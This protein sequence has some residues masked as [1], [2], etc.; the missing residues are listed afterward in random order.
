MNSNVNILY[1]INKRFGVDEHN[2]KKILGSDVGIGISSYFIELGNLNNTNDIDYNLVMLN[3]LGENYF[4]N[5]E[6]VSFLVKRCFTSSEIDLVAVVLRI[7]VGKGAFE[8]KKLILEKS[9]AQI[10]KALIQVLKL[11]ANFFSEEKRNKIITREKIKPFTPVPIEESKCRE[12]IHK[13]Y[14]NL[15]DYQKRIKDRVIQKILF[16]KPS[17]KLLIH[18]PTGSGKTKTAMETIIDFI[19]VKLRPTDE[20]GTVVWFAHSKELCEQAYDTFKSLWLYKGDFEISTCKVFDDAD[21]VEVEKCSKEKVNV[22]FVGFQKFNSLRTRSKKTLLQNSILHF[23]KT[24]TQLVVVDEAHKSLATT[25]EEAISFTSTMPN[26]RLIGLTATPGRSN[27]ITG[28]NENDRLSGY[29]GND[30]VT[31]T[32]EKGEKVPDPLTYLQELNVLA[33]IEQEQLDFEL[34]FAH[35]GYSS[36]ELEQISESDGLGEKEIN[37]LATDPYRNMIIINKIR[38]NFN[39]G[40]SILVFAC[41]LDHCFILAGIL[42]SYSINS[43]VVTGSTGKQTRSNS[44]KAFKNGSLK[45]LINFGVLSTG[46]DAP[47]L[48]TLII[49]RPTKSIVLYSQIVGRAL[50]GTANGGNEKN[51]LITIKDN[52]LGFPDPTFMFSYWDEFWN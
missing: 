42:S 29:F 23:I 40:K 19:K 38:D 17:A 9:K 39:E 25:Y 33:K 12:L 31:I 30:I 8:K 52:L 1:D 14:L 41:S 35:K 37:L 26:C 3:S 16:T 44:I 5:F 22:L 6:A 36:N 18:M 11:D 48:N 51:K 24:T 2:F 46:F 45:V 20:G 13:E 27:Y 4:S 7:D 32:N 49:A 43:K 15:H 10:K 28:D 34:N 47:K 50:R 21:Y